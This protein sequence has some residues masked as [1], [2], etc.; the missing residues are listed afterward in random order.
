M[1]VNTCPLYHCYRYFN[2]QFKFQP[3]DEISILKIISQIKYNATVNDKYDLKMI[4]I[5]CP[6]ILPFIIHIINGFLEW[7]WSRHCRRH[8]ILLKLKIFAESV[9]YLN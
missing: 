6:H 8:Q 4:K 7:V 5:C 9:F 2:N 1:Y 3:A